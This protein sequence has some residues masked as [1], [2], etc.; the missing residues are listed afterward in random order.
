MRSIVFLSLALLSFAGA[1]FAAPPGVCPTVPVALELRT[2]GAKPGVY[3]LVFTTLDHEDAV[4]PDFID[5]HYRINNE[6]SVN[7]RALSQ[8]SIADN[9]QRAK[10][11][12]VD[13]IVLRPGDALRA[14]ATYSARGYACDTA[15]HTFNAPEYDERDVRD[16]RFQTYAMPYTYAPYAPYHAGAYAR[17]DPDEFWIQAALEEEAAQRDHAKALADMSSSVAACPAI[18]SDEQ[19]LKQAGSE[20]TYVLSFENRNPSQQLEYVDLHVSNDQHGGWDNLRLASDMQLTLAHKVLQPGIVMRPDE[21]LRWYWSYRAA[22]KDGRVVDC[23]TPIRTT[24]ADMVNREVDVE[25]IKQ[26]AA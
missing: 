19:I 25:Q 13:G 24:S 11:A 14:Y 20:D 22:T 1:A 17:A 12:Q 3:K 18:D 16:T 21:Q 8:M 15:V 2:S 10:Q 23:T 26:M 5:I 7:L 9:S 4:Q 6:D